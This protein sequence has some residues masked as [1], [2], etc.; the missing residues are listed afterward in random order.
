M[1][2]K[3]FGVGGKM[4]GQQQ[5]NNLLGSALLP[6]TGVS[7]SN[8]PVAKLKFGLIEENLLPI[9]YCC[10]WYII[11]VIG[12]IPFLKVSILIYLFMQRR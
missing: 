4:V 3:S 11:L 6:Y 7:E 5:T 9:L 2:K 1:A 8:I 10:H 12:S